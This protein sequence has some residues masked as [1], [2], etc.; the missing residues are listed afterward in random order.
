MVEDPG[1]MGDG[2]I[3]QGAMVPLLP[4][5][6]DVDKPVYVRESVR[7]GPFQ[8]QILGCKVKPL[9]GESAQVMVMP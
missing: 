4:V 8:T 2:P 7:L 5:S 3:E 9:I 6:Q 1:A